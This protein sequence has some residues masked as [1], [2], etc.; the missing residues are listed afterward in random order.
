MNINECPIVPNW[1]MTIRNRQITRQKYQHLLPA[2][3]RRIQ[4][5]TDSGNESL[6]QELRR[7]L[8]IL[9]REI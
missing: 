1:A 3:R 7:E 9:E 8:A 4:S 6:V 5:A 2:L